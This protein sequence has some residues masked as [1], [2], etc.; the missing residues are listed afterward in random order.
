MDLSLDKAMI[1]ELER[2]LKEERL[3]DKMNVGLLLSIDISLGEYIAHWIPDLSQNELE[4]LAGI[5]R[6]SLSKKQKFIAKL[7]TRRMIGD[8]A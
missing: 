3:W 4:E 2:I 5:L 1:K 7:V 6:D 8:E